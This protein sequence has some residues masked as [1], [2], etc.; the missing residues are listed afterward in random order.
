MGFP[1]NPTAPF[2]IL[3]WLA[4]ELHEYAPNRHF[5]KSGPPLH[6]PVKILIHKNTHLAFLVKN[7]KIIT[8][9]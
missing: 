8:D 3:T 6:E 7:K 2:P 9:L 4:A 1:Q 5:T